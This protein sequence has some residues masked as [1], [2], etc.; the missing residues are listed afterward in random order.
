MRDYKFETRDGHAHFFPHIG[1]T[2][3]HREKAELGPFMT[4]T[5]ALGRLLFLSLEMVLM[6]ILGFFLVR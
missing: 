3:Y 5:L 1:Y 6:V 4:L 2:Y